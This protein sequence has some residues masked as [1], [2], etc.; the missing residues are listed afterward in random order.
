MPQV[1][2]ERRRLF[3]GKVKGHNGEMV[4]AV[5]AGKPVRNTPAIARVNVW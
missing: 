3:V 4:Q 1:L 5:S 2:G